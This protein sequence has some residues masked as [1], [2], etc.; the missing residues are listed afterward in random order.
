MFVWA[1]GLAGLSA[2][3]P[4]NPPQFFADLVMSDSAVGRD[5]AIYVAG[6]ILEEER[7]QRQERVELPSFSSYPVPLLDFYV[8]KISPD[9][10]RIEFLEYFGGSGD[11]FVAAIAVD[12][13]GHIYVSGITDSEDFPSR[14]SPPT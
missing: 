4:P 11:D 14:A 9:G 12:D 3:E 2:V 5:G 13:L 1:F 8:A 7:E 6:S 10:D